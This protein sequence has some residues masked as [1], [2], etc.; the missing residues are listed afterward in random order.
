MGSNGSRRPFTCAAA[1]LAAIFLWGGCAAPEHAP[2]SRPSVS[3]AT[4]PGNSVSLTGSEMP[5]MYRELLAIDLPTVLRVAGADNLDIRQ[6][7]ERYEAAKGRYESSVEAIFPVIAPGI[8][9]QHLEGVNQNAN[10][11]LANANFNNLLPFVAIQWI[12]NPGQVVYDIVASKRRMEASDRQEQAVVL[13]TTRLAASQYYDL[14][15]AR[16]RLGVAQQSVAEAEELLRITRLK[17]QAGTGVPV[18]ELRAQ[19]S[20]AGLQQDV[21][22]ALNSFYQSSVALTLTLHLDPVVTL[23]PQQK[24]IDQLTL[25]RADMTIEE[26]LATALTYRPDLEAARTLVRAAHADTKSTAWG[27]FGPQVQAGYQFGE[28]QTKIPS[29]DYVYHAQQ[30]ASAAA[31]FSLGASTFGRIKTASADERSAQIDLQREL[32]R[33]R[34]AVVSAQQNSLTNGK[35]VPVARQQLDAA[36]SALHQAQANLKAGTMLTVDVLQ[37]EDSVAQARLQF[38]DAVVHYNQAQI[39]L[40]ASLGLLAP[41]TSVTA[42]ME[43]A[44]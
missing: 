29:K 25:V 22:L 19:A 33:V 3:P 1:L 41:D 40:M 21:L 36:Q 37:A 24:Q 13:E 6:A 5:P 20:L 34:A 8:A 27:G 39:D 16:A 4:Q 2:T 17:V 15:L 42:A 28:L 30:K 18:D 43:P 35:L 14:V 31:G 38:V 12:L 11:T 23:V 26:M 7:R 9:Y 44:P 10:G 32:D